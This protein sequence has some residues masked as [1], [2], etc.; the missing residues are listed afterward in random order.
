MRL[1]VHEPMNTVSTG[2]SRSA[3]RVRGPCT[4]APRDR[5]ARGRVG[6]V[7]GR[8]DAAVDRAVLAGVR[9][10]RDLRRR[11]GGVDDDLLVERGAVV[12]LQRAPVG[13]GGFPRIALRRVVAALEV[14]E[15]GVVGR[16]QAGAG[17]RLDRHVAQR[18]PALHREA[19]IAE[20]RYSMTWPMPPPVPISPMIARI[21]VLRRDAG[22]QVALDRDRHR[23]RARLRERLRGEHVLDLAGADAERERPERAVR[24][25]V[26]VAAHDRHAGLREALLGPDHV[27]DAL[28]GIAHREDGDAELGAV[29]AS[30][31]ICLAEIGSAI[32]RWMSAVGT[33]WSSSRR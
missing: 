13:E 27:D 5:L 11:V 33:L 28:V 6:V 32:G 22:G 16:D 7:V 3:C 8:R 18:H 15:R 26:A 30:V 19:R 1:F 24:R 17:A 12:G 21:D 25:R 29:A 9:A 20:P 10:P 31:S 23:L 4:R 14:G 2:I